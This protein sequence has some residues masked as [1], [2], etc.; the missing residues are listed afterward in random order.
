MKSKILKYSTI[1]LILS[2]LFFI[3]SYRSYIIIEATILITNVNTPCN[4]IPIKK[5]SEKAKAKIII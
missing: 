4:V 1:I 2:I 3:L 5:K